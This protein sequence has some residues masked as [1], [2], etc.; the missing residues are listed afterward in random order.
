MKRSTIDE[1]DSQRL[2]GLEV[3]PGVQQ[4]LVAKYF[5]GPA[6]GSEDNL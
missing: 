1:I 5:S 6:G 4:R 2:E 3:K